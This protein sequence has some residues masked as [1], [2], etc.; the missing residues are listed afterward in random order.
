MRVKYFSIRRCVI[1]ILWTFALPAI[2]PAQ[3]IGAGS[4][5]PLRPVKKQV[6]DTAQ[7]KVYYEY[8]FREDST[9]V[10][11][12]KHG[13]TV[14]LLGDTFTGFMDYNRLTRDSINDAYYREGKSPMEYMAKAFT[15]AAPT[16]TYDLLSDI[17]GNTTTVYFDAT[18]LKIQYSQATPQFDW[19][20]VEA[21]SVISGVKCKK[22]TYMFG[23][24]R[25]TAWYSLDY[26]L[27]FGPYMF[28]G[29]PG[30]IFAVYDDRRDHTFVLNGLETCTGIMPIYLHAGS[31]IIKSSREKARSTI[32]RFFDD[33]SV[34]MQAKYPGTV[35]PDDLKGKKLSSPYNPIELE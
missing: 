27:P 2:V 20:L 22:A 7:V 30:L 3:T 16:F 24:R 8:T 14:L 29:L 13:Q 5:P 9:K 28:R 18:S 23:G 12:V 10:N 31:D 6:Y 33:A 11:S 21:D 17:R 15:L 32:E 26:N 35:F 25:W 4:L 1:S 34:F 19:S